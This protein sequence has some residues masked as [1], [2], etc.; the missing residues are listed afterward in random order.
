MLTVQLDAQG[1]LVNGKTFEGFCD[2]TPEETPLAVAATPASPTGGWLE[3][4]NEEAPM[5]FLT[6]STL[7]LQRTASCGCC[8]SR[9]GF[10]LLAWQ[11]S[12]GGAQAW[13][14]VTSTFCVASV[15]LGDIHFVLRRRRGTYGTGLGLVTRL[16]AFGAAAFCVAGVA[17]GDIHLRC[18]WQAWRLV[19]FIFVWRGTYGTGLGLVTRLV[20][21]G[22]AAVLRGR[23]GTWRGTY[24]TGLGLVTRLV[25][26][27]AAARLRGRRGTYGTEL[28]LV[29]RLV[30]FGAP[31]VLR[32]RRVRSAQRG[33]DEAQQD[34]CTLLDRLVST[35]CFMSAGSGEKNNRGYA[36]KHDGGG[37][38]IHLGCFELVSAETYLEQDIPL[39]IRGFHEQAVRKWQMVSQFWEDLCHAA[40]WV[41]KSFA[42][43]RMFLVIEVVRLVARH[44]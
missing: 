19:T 29:M 22:A 25:A 26:F 39:H 30:A 41:F 8:T 14:L 44:G 3:V 7:R 28:G 20:A 24:G 42:V 1:R 37:T 2:A 15:A 40:E 11:D 32:G 4:I 17:L 13:H 35:V 21:F 34:L 33:G 10:R 27:G 6:P 31:A 16:V 5:S 9:A 23:R 43:S 38:A 18:L 12:C 36:W